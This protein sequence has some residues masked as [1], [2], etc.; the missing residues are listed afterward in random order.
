MSA[1]DVRA[2][3]REQAILDELDTLDEVDC[4]V[5]DV[6]ALLFDLAAESRD[7][8]EVARLREIAGELL[9]MFARQ[10]GVIEAV[11]GDGDAVVR[12]LADLAD[13]RLTAQELS[14]RRQDG[15]ELARE[16][17]VVSEAL[18]DERLGLLADLDDEDDEDDE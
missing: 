16:L 1:A 14:R 5:K 11:D 3:Q 9:P 18:A 7:R 13:R 12:L 15:R 8:G 10:L 2:L 17:L 6:A 4:V